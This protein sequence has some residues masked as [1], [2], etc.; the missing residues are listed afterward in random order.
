[1]SDLSFAVVE[2]RAEPYAAVPTLAF[3]L[4]IEES[5]GE[6]I[7]A[8]AL[9]CQIQIEPRRRPYTQA[10][11]EGLL[12]LFGAPHRWG[13][14]LR[15]VLWLH[16]SLV[17]P[18]FEGSTEIDLPVACTYDFE[19]TAAKY[20]QALDDGEIP[21]L[22]LF[23]GTVFVRG[24]TGFSV[25]PVPWEKEAAYRLPVRVW[26]ELMDRYFPGS[27]WLRLSRESVEA[28]GRFKARRGLTSWDET[29]AVLLREA[30]G[31]ELPA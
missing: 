3:R 11:A 19:V 22:L 4:R 24:A 8:L 13:E 14:T 28:V 31:E 1:M 30:G 26:R 5:T 17:V 21:L 16:A 25:E 2:A 7:H 10:E 9:R 27:S 6:R 15:T 12:E 18:G 20:F 29:I 23:S